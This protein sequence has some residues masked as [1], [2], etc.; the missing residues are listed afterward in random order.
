MDSI[1]AFWMPDDVTGFL[2]KITPSTPLALSQLPYGSSRILGQL[3]TEL[4][5][6]TDTDLEYIIS[7]L[8]GEPEVAPADTTPEVCE[9]ILRAYVIVAA[10][11]IHRPYFAQK[12]ELPEAIAKPIWDFS[13]YVGRPPSLTYASYVLAN[14]SNKISVRS[15]P[16]DIKVAQTLTGTSD[17]EWFIAVHLSAETVGA[18]VVAAIKRMELALQSNNIE[19]LTSA[20]ESIEAGVLFAKSIFAEVA[21]NIDPTVF[22]ES[23]RP[24]LFGHD[25][26]RFNG[27]SGNPEVTYVGETG[28][29]SGMMRAVDIALG[30]RHSDHVI[31][32]FKHFVLCAPP[33]HQEFFERTSK[34]GQQLL[35]FINNIYIKKARRNALLAVAE[36]R[37]VHLDIVNYFLVENGRKLTD[38]GTGGTDFLI[39]LGNLVNE[40]EADAN[41]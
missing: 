5:V 3:S 12:K 30:T 11:L 9:G 25:R 21:G 32:S 36:L 2:P 29:Q 39:W 20:L 33:S 31:S 37:R 38:K 19:V 24:L 15:K 1:S 40:T 35:G 10:H 13:K 16:S 7:S 34:T 6:M 22:R 28:A 8:K 18:E 23:I 41:T 17:E 4:G 26:I 14:F 27:V